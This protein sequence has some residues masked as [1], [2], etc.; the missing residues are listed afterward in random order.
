[1]SWLITGSEKNPTDPYR[2]SVTLLLIGNGT[3]G[4]TNILDSGTNPRIVTANGDAKISTLIS[5]PFGNPTTGVIKFDGVGDNLHYP[6]T[7]VWTNLQGLTT[8]FTV[9]AWIY[10]TGT[11]SQGS[12]IIGINIGGQTSAVSFHITNSTRYLMFRSWGNFNYTD[13]TSN[14]TAISLNTWSHVVASKS[15]TTMRLF[16]NGTLVGTQII[17]SATIPSLGSTV[18]Q[19]GGRTTDD[20]LKF[21]GY[22][23]NI[24]ISQDIT[25]YVEGTGANAGKMVFTGTNTLALPTKSFTDI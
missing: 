9:E 4:S 1:M 23:S 10:P 21:V 19:I 18:V 12:D 13:T 14:P 2:S 17:G 15:G 25:R 16:I 20:V 22:M 24:R 6:A 5:D 11:G 8:N 7:S 3:D